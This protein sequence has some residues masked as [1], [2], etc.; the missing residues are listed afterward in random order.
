MKG[1]IQ[2]LLGSIGQSRMLSWNMGSLA[3]GSM[4]EGWGGD[5]E[6]H[7]TSLIVFTR[8]CRGQCIGKGNSNTGTKSLIFQFILLILFWLHTLPL[9]SIGSCHYQKLLIILVGQ[10]TPPWKPIWEGWFFPKNGFENLMLNLYR[11]YL[12]FTKGFDGLQEPCPINLNSKFL[13]CVYKGQIIIEGL[14]TNLVLSFKK[15]SC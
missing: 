7:R 8:S 12:N 14:W 13:P 9:P 5:N 11:L 10:N 3:V 6:D 15:I 2:W 4:R 1:Q